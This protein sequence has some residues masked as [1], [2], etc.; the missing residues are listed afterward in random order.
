VNKKTFSDMLSRKF[1]YLRISVTDRCNYRCSYCMPSEVFNNNYSYIAQNKILSYEEIIHLCSILKKIGLTKIRITGGEPLLRK[2]IDKLIHKLKTESGINNVSMTT[3]GSLLTDSKLKQLKSSGL[4]SIT[5]SLDTL[6]SKKITKINGT[7]KYFDLDTVLTGIEKYFTTVKTNTVVI[8]NI[9][10]DEVLDIVN[11]ISAL[12]SEIRFIE[13]MDVGESNN[14][15]FSKII[16]SQEL[17]ELI[18]SKYELSVINTDKSSTSKKWALKNTDS[19]VGFISSITEPFCNDCN[20]AR[21]SV[22]GKIYTCLFASEG[23]DIKKIIRTS[24][25][26][27]DILDYFYNLWSKR[28]DRYSEVRFMQK[29]DSPKVEMSYIGG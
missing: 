14:W 20:R 1:E 16:P 24:R 19:S 23:H 6:D 13:Y 26:D 7:K 18:N 12:R 11:K 10:D 15:D 29:K 5:L 25:S 21:L 28:S 4:D 3:N 27:Q 17:Y 9:N 8:K 22:D 2:N